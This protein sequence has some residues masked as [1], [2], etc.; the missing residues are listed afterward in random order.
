VHR[1]TSRNGPA[2]LLSGGHSSSGGGAKWFATSTPRRDIGFGSSR[3]SAKNPIYFMLQTFDL[4]LDFDR[5][6]QLCQ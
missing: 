1:S 3:W 5:P 2:R 6:F 4:L